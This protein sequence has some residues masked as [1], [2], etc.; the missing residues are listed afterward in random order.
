[1]KGKKTMFKKMNKS[2]LLMPILLGAV[3]IPSQLNA[4]LIDEKKLSASVTVASDYVFRGDSKTNNKNSIKSDLGYALSD[5]LSIAA[6]VGNVE[7]G[8]ATYELKLGGAYAFDC[9]GLKSSIGLTSYL[10]PNAYDDVTNSDDLDFHEVSLEVSH[11]GFTLGAHTTTATEASGYDTGTNTYYNLSYTTALT[12]SIDLT[13]GYGMY[14]TPDG[15]A[16]PDGDQKDYLISLAKGPYTL[17]WTDT[18]AK[19]TV[20]ATEKDVEGIF[21]ASYKLEI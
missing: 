12:E 21:T 16:G 5:D 3:C 17:T 2:L 6:S 20:G 14:N 13:L 18:D 15:I 4:S 9:F 19:K 1:M 11:S 8:N 10:Y 7:V